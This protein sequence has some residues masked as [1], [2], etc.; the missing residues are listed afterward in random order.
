MHAAKDK[1]GDQEKNTL[2]R[3]SHHGRNT[4]MPRHRRRR[5]RSNT[6]S[7]SSDR[8][9]GE[10]M[11]LALQRPAPGGGHRIRVELVCA[12]NARRRHRRGSGKHAEGHERSL[13]RLDAALHTRRRSTQ[14]LRLLVDRR[15]RGT[16][17]R[18]RSGPKRTPRG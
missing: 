3:T 16:P 5:Q 8:W 18:M 13:R 12:G 11:E 4:G 10:A 1:K 17:K 2:P 6:S 14:P 15:D 7:N 9:P